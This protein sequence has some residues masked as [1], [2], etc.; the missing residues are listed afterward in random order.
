M[1]RWAIYID[2]EGFSAVYKTDEVRAIS[3]L[4]AVMQG[5][6]HIG[7]TVCAESPKR[8]FVHQTGDGFAIVSEFAEGSPGLP[9]AI[10]TI[11]MRLALSA[12]CLT[13]AGI[14][15]GEFADIRGCY[16]EAITRHS[17]SDGVV[18]L[19][20]G[21]MRLFPVMGTAL[22]NAHHLTTRAKGALLILDATMASGVSGTAVVSAEF[23]DFLVID[24]IHADS[25]DIRQIL[26]GT[27]IAVDQTG[28]LEQRL[29]ASVAAA[30][31]SVSDD[32]VKNTLAFNGCS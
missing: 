3:A 13:K 19:G 32:W 14:S 31:T 24:W 30:K 20:R 8:L 18:R 11:L 1:R 22:I 29:R 9:V 27:S 6:Y 17:D 16:P 2:V 5:I 21:I 23:R 26:T 12:G 25:P 15:E 7:T 28:V 4:G 10:T